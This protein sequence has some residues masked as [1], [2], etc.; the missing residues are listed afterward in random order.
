MAKKVIITC[1]VTGA[2]FTPTMS[3]HLPYRPDD[4]VDQAVAAHE[5]GAAVLHLHA[6]DPQTGEPSADP[7]L[8]RSYVTRIK[9]RTEN[10]V[11]SLTK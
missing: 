9:E 11:I 7:E 3:P 2:S 10:A 4:I 5:A 8:F 1:A 6:R